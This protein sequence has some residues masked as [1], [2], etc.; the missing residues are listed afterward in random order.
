MTS[1]RPDADPGAPEQG[2]HDR[3]LSR[4]F[5]TLFIAILCGVVLYEAATTLTEK[6]YASGTPI[7]NAALY[8]RLLAGLLLFLLALQVVTDIR[9]KAPLTSSESPAGPGHGRQTA[10]AALAIIAYIVILPIMGFLLA[11]PLFVLTFLL[12]LGDRH[13]ATLVLVPLATTV[14]CVVVFQVLFNVNLP[15]GQFGFAVNF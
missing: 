7:S 3:R 5:P 13:A 12:L 8:P 6:G 14:G 15:R 1:P 2:V 11:T 10:P 4:H 9:S